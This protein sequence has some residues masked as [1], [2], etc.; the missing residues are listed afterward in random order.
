MYRNWRAR[1]EGTGMAACDQGTAPARDRHWRGREQGRGM[2]ACGQG[3]APASA[4]SWTG[5]GH[6]RVGEQEWRLAMRE[7]P[8]AGATN[9]EP[10]ERANEWPRI[11]LGPTPPALH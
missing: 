6:L 4:R 2:A 10:G 7:Q 9:C 11:T 1:E 3:A 8:Q 5:T